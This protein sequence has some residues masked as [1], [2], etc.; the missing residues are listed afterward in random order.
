M[1][2][3]LNENNIPWKLKNP[4]TP[5]ILTGRKASSTLT[6]KCSGACTLY[7]Y[8]EV[9]LTG[10]TASQVIHWMKRMTLNGNWNRLLPS[11]W[12]RNRPLESIGSFEMAI[13]IHCMFINN[14]PMHFKGHLVSFLFVHPRTTMSPCE[15]LRQVA[16]MEF[17][18]PRLRSDA[19][20]L[21]SKFHWACST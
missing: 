15:A 7:I 8:L 19:C 17:D 11:T 21:G 5:S 1:N 13:G 9:S 4:Q 6:M 14:K 16:S 20:F 12:W 18:R 10:L 3:A 2:Y